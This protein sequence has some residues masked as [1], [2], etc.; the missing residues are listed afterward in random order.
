[1]EISRFFFF[2]NQRSHIPSLQTYI[3]AGSSEGKIE[4]M[5]ETSS[6]P[7]D[8]RL[9]RAREAAVKGN[10][11]VEGAWRPARIHDLRIKSA[12]PVRQPHEKSVAILKLGKPMIIF[13]NCRLRCN[14][15]RTDLCK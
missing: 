7:T 12:P 10:R 3:V 1:M 4:N 14:C 8:C 5:R 11:G 13:S 9:N 2:T 15:K 6:E